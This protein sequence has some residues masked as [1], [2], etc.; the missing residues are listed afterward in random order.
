[1]ITPSQLGQFLNNHA[2]IIEQAHGQQSSGNHWQVTMPGIELSNN[3]RVKGRF[4]INPGKLNV[5]APKAAHAYIEFMDNDG[6]A[7]FTDFQVIPHKLPEVQ[8]IQIKPSYRGTE[9]RRL[10]DL[11][12]VQFLDILKLPPKIILESKQSA[13][14]AHYKAGYKLTNLDPDHV[15]EVKARIKRLNQG[16]KLS[17]A[18]LYN[19][20]FRGMP[21]MRLSPRLIDQYRRLPSAWPDSFRRQ[22]KQM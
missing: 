7:G 3:K 11:M 12:C 2:K 13:F 22:I 14:P 19:D 9:L 16:E 15:D 6:Q 5:Q 8:D 1:M 18:D 10:C 17:L 20:R 21:M 4:F